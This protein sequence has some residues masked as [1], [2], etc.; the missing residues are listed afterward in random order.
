MIKLPDL[1]QGRLME[2]ERKTTQSGSTQ[3]ELSKERAAADLDAALELC[4][5]ES[6]MKQLGEV[7]KARGG[8]SA[9]ARAAGL[10]R[11][12]LYKI[13][14]AEGNPALHTLVSL[15]TP[16]GLRLSVKPIAEQS[17]AT[18]SEPANAIG[19]YPGADVYAQSPSQ[20]EI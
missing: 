11:T 2:A 19:S 20:G 3:K 5:V 6:F 17:L 15:L 9:A 1:Q 4:D 8:Y 14:S 16:L 7:I 10:N 13:A 18:V 12:A